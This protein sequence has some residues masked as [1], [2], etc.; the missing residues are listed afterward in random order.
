MLDPKVFK[1]YDVRGIYPAEIDAEGGR[2]IGRAF[3][4]QFEPKRI[5]AGRDMRL[6]SPEMAAAAILGAAEAGADVLDLGMSGRSRSR[7]PE[8]AHPG[9]WRHTT[10]G[11]RTSTG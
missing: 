10:S 6:S 7:G 2:A 5:A 8:R 1:A 3:V 4:E 9:R 11:R